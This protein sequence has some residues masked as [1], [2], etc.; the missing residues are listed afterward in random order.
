MNNKEQGPVSTDSDTGID[1][2]SMTDADAGRNWHPPQAPKGVKDTATTSQS[3][4]QPQSKKK[5][6]DKK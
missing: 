3:L 4:P 1:I 6:A 5:V 2:Y